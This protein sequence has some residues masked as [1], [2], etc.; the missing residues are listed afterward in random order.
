MDQDEAA[1]FVRRFT[2]F[3]K[4]PAPERLDTVLAPRAR[5]SAPLIPTTC[6]LD[7]GKRTF[8]GIFELIPDMTVEVQ[9]RGA[10]SD[11]VLIE[12]TF[13]GTAN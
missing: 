13:R 7:A 1:D 12:F 2:E 6:G 3:W 8:A 5:L 10:T 4:A 11:G 9:R